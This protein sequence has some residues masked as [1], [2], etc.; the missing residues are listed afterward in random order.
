MIRKFECKNC[1]KQFEADDKKMVSCPH[2]QSDNVEIASFRISPL[3]WKVGAGVLALAIIV[4]L[5]FPTSGKDKDIMQIEEITSNGDEIGERSDS[6]EIV[7]GLDIPPTIEV[8]DMSF[9]GN[10]YSLKVKAYNVP[11]S[12]TYIAILNPFDNTKRIAKSDDGTFKNVPSS[13]VDGAYYTIALVDAATDSII[14]SIEKPGFIEQSPVATKMTISELQQKI[15]SRDN[16]LLG[17]GE[18][19]YLAP[20]YKLKFIGLSSDAVN[21]PT[22]LAEVTDK[23]DMETWASAKVTALDYDDKNRVSAITLKVELP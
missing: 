15:D 4:A 6:T 8:G 16:S 12:K 20:D 22:I 23:L 18:N 7:P 17:A 14:C 5:L 3:V 13:D 2:C 11:V 9:E 21:I 10:G 1:G 19:D